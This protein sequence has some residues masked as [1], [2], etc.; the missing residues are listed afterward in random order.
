[1]L[2]R[3]Q[4]HFVYFTAFTYSTSNLNHDSQFVYL[5]QLVLLYSGRK[6]H[7]EGTGRIEDIYVVTTTTVGILL[8]SS[9]YSPYQARKMCD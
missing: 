8:F 3:A 6:V 4:L 5:F 2:L 7:S 1:M 9:R